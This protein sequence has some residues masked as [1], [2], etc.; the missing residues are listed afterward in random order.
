M[1]QAFRIADQARGGEILVS[2]RVRELAEGATDLRFD[3]GREVLLKGL[4]GTHRIF[5]VHW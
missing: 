3:E 5:G 4:S 1:I 2:S